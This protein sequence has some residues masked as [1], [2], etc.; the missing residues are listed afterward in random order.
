MLS[1]ISVLQSTSYA[2]TPSN[3][4]YIRKQSGKNRSGVV[5]PANG[6][7]VSPVALWKH[8]LPLL[9]SAQ[10]MAGLRNN[11]AMPQRWLKLASVTGRRAYWPQQHGSILENCL[12]T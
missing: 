11:C 5:P 4:N 7:N 1:S 12:L 6:I 10:K 2:H 3:A 8:L 9:P